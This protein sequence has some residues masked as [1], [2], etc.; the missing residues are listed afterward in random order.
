MTFSAGAEFL[1]KGLC[2]LRG[3]EIR[4]VDSV[5]DYPA[6]SLDGWVPR[7]TAGTAPLQTVSKYGS[8]GTLLWGT[9][10]GPSAI[11]RLCEK[12]NAPYWEQ[13]RLIAAFKL[14]AGP[15]RN[16]DAHA[17]RPNERDAH[18]WLVGGLFAPCLN[19]LISWLPGGSCKLN[20]WLDDSE[21]F[22]EGLKA[23]S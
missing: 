9:S 7:V 23:K 13:E 11:A 3:I 19:A 2:L 15:I 8:L 21:S 22:I 5:L 17:Y 16:R 12:V 6:E 10:T 1:A 14:L 18:F 20:E 4:K